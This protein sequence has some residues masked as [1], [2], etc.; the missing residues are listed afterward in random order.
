MNDQP[1]ADHV[2]LRSTPPSIDC[3]SHVY[4][5]E[6]L[7]FL[8]RRKT[9]PMAFR[10]NGEIYV[11]VGE[12]PLQLR[13]NHTSIE[14]KLAMM[15]EERIGVT[16][17]ST[18]FPGPELLGSEGPAL[19]RIMNDYVADVVRRHPERFAGLAVLP[20]QDVGAS[21]KELHRAVEDL[22]LHG[23]MLFSN[24]NGRF[25]DEP[26][27]LPLLAA[28]A[29]L[30]APVVL[31]PSHPVAFEAT[32]G[33]QMTNGLGWMFDTTIALARMI[34]GGVLE[35]HPS[36]RIVCPHVGGTLPYLIGRIDHQ[37]LVLGRGG[38]NLSQPPSEYLRKVYFDTAS[39]MALA[40][41]Y[42]YDFA[43]PDQI[44]FATDHPWVAP[45]LIRDEIS[46]LDLSPE[47]ET[48]ILSSNAKRLFQI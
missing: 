20:T 34:L 33:Y 42:I 45:K 7:E 6:V 37:V 32:R 25:A 44:L 29:D 11:Q 17:L 27:F 3:Q 47:D 12:W 24:Q 26:E 41:R 13:P 14:A 48:K 39:V 16:M 43:G 36:L 18:N 15:N 1:A 21:I 8:E 38:E 35:R 4:I 10:R 31:H 30:G 22:R 40:I 19:A 46:K 9:S 2:R 23:L 28:A 5:P